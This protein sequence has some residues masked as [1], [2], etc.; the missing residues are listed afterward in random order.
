[1]DLI[2][3]SGLWY[4]ADHLIHS[5]VMCLK[6]HYCL[7]YCFWFEIYCNSLCKCVHPNGK[8]SLTRTCRTAKLE[9]SSRASPSR[10]D[11]RS[12]QFF[13]RIRCHAICG[14]DLRWV[15]QPLK[16]KLRVVSFAR[17]DRGASLDTQERRGERREGGKQEGTSVIACIPKP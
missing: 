1:M 16:A 15:V 9:P 13:S 8:Q 4:I 12:R 6:I 2:H 7:E 11:S 5:A 10:V 17:A 3:L 14:C